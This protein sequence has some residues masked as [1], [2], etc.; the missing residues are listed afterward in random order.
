MLNEQ[1]TGL[2][3]LMNNPAINGPAKRLAPAISQD[4]VCEHS[5]V[6]DDGLHLEID[7]NGCGGA[8][9][10]TNS[11]CMTS[12]LNILQKG[13]RPEAVVLK[14]FNH[15][16]YRRVSLSRVFGLADELANLRRLASD[17]HLSDKRCQTCPA[18][19]PKVA[20]KLAEELK[21]NP[22]EY[23]TRAKMVSAKAEADASLTCERAHACM[24]HVIESSRFLGRC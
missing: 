21:R 24:A 9:D 22:I 1:G 20:S 7:C 2:E 4:R 11:R 17:E 14:R 5:F 16:R 19:M 10:L 15:M 6:E 8:Q 23:A 18:S 13:V 12:V 3:K